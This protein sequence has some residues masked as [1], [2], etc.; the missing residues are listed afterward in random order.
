MKLE[1]LFVKFYFVNTKCSHSIP[2]TD[3]I[4]IKI[5]RTDCN[6]V[7]M[8]IASGP[9][10]LERLELITIILSSK[11]RER[12]VYSQPCKVQQNGYMSVSN[13]PALTLIFKVARS[14]MCPQ[15]P[16][17]VAREVSISWAVHTA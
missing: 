3:R 7:L 14:L 5:I 16:S 10:F 11:T 6:W 4:T 8:Q 12:K 1:N 9:S 2:L 17:G 15:N 13:H